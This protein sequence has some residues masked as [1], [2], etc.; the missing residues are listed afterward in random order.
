MVTRLQNEMLLLML[1]LESLMTEV[2]IMKRDAVDLDVGKME[3]LF[4]GDGDY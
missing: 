2:E 1:Q 4:S 3:L